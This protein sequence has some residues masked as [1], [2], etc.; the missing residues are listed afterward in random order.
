MGRWGFLESLITGQILLRCSFKQ[1]LTLL[2]VHQE[3]FV[4]NTNYSVLELPTSHEPIFFLSPLFHK[5]ISVSGLKAQTSLWN[6]NRFPHA[7]MP[8]F[9]TQPIAWGSCRIAPSFLLI[10]F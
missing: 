7:R 3:N 2:V 10:L 6:E 1:N 4:F 9:L 5:H 8:V